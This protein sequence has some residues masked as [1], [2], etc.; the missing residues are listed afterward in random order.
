VKLGSKQKDQRGQSFLS[1]PPN[2][3]VLAHLV[4]TAQKAMG[5]AVS[6][7][8]PVPG[9]DFFYLLEVYIP[10]DSKDFLGK[11][12]N[13]GSREP[14]W[15]LSRCTEET[16]SELFSLASGDVELILNLVLSEATTTK[17]ASPEPSA[18][19]DD[20]QTG[21]KAVGEN[22]TDNAIL[23]SR[24]RASQHR[25]PAAITLAGEIAEIELSGVFQ[26]IMIC[27]MSGRLDVQGAM[28]QAEI[29]FQEGVLTHATMQSAFSS[30]SSQDLIGD[31][32]LLNVLTWDAGSFAFQKDRKSSTKTVR[33]RLEVLLLEG[34]TLRDY[35][36]YLRNFSIGLDT[37]LYS[38]NPNLAEPE[39][40]KALASGVSIDGD[41]QK[42]FYR[43]IDGRRSLDA[44]IRELK[45][46]Q[47]TWIAVVFNLLNLRLVTP[48]KNAQG[49]K[50]EMVGPPPVDQ[51]IIESEKRNL[52][53][54]ETGLTSFP[55]FFHF[56]EVELSRNAWRTS[57][58]SVVILE[59]RNRS[60]A[61][62]NEALQQAANCFAALKEPFDLF[63]HY[64]L[65]DFAI[66]VPLRVDEECRSLL[67][68]FNSRLRSLTLHGVASPEDLS[69]FF[70]VASVP[71]DADQPN[72][73]L[74]AAERAK[75]HAMAK[76][77]LIST[78]RDLRWEDHRARA[79]EAAGE[80]NRNKEE[81]AWR[82]AV[83]EAEQFAP[84][85]P[86]IAFS[87]E[88]LAKHY[89][90][91]RQWENAEQ[92]LR[93]VL[94]MKEARDGEQSL[95]VGSTISQLANCLYR[96]EKHHDAEFFLRRAVSIYA[97]KLGPDH[98][99]VANS[100]SYLGAACAAQGKKNAAL[101]CYQQGLTIFERTLGPEHPKT[102][103]MRGLYENLAGN[104]QTESV[105]SKA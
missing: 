87:A 93:K 85:D 1:S 57:P 18:L 84:D 74:I 68:K 76:G 25:M 2:Q 14:H 20:S 22:V 7:N 13:V 97:A 27:K 33:R 16:R 103:R 67:E 36:K 47:N 92:A 81:N 75:N 48:D 51:V 73:L 28:Q 45:L 23:R 52:V 50:M 10:S 12:Q 54:P 65:C 35:H 96:L 38:Q 49:H 26:S 86:R 39:I 56:L 29:F 101:Y 42:R 24:M 37:I 40:E 70:G 11:T 44:I 83:S 69:L 104:Q 71:A 63:A 78:A 95:T 62:S 17:N 55:M 99:S 5:K 88:Q 19:N 77:V 82:Q 90:E 3:Q 41:L 94:V 58:F 98:E 100:L 15:T 43:M 8:W 31:E 53:R 59:L 32:V 46:S 21:L 89:F 79:T 9:S 102:S 34:A 30:D 61:L 80:Q 66:L 64:K 4:S 60:E 91:T 6:A 72:T 105:P